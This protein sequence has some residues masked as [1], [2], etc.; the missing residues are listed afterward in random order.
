M[1]PNL[2]NPGIL[3]EPVGESFWNVISASPQPQILPC[4][5]P[6]KERMPCLLRFQACLRS[7]SPCSTSSSSQPIV[8]IFSEWPTLLAVMSPW[9]HNAFGWRTQPYSV[10][11]RFRFSPR[12]SAH[13]RHR[14]NPRHRPIVRS[15][16]ER[17]LFPERSQSSRILETFAGLRYHLA[18]VG[19][20]GS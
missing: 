4:K 20:W 15:D 11:A 3:R 8:S 19:A 9:R 7:C 16:T 14:P 6:S 5:A 12:C 17:S 10:A 1:L 18:Q 2:G 13:A